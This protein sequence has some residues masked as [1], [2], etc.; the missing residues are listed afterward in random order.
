MTERKATYYRVLADGKV[1]CTLC[2]QACR[3]DEGE[4]GRCR[5][6]VARGKELYT[7]VRPS[8]R[9]SAGPDREKAALPFSPGKPRL[10]RGNGRV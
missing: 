9:L 2:P 5:G 8:F 1:L 6:R 7:V 3:L 4:S 10:I